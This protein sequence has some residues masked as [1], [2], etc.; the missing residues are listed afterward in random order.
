MIYLEM[1]K[2]S[3]DKK[4]GMGR[5]VRELS[6][7]GIYD[8]VL[9]AE[10]QKK[11]VPACI[12]TV[13][14]FP[15]VCYYS[16]ANEFIQHNLSDQDIIHFPMNIC[17]FE[18]IPSYVKVVITIHDLI[19]II[20]YSKNGDSGNRGSDGRMISSADFLANIEKGVERANLIISVSKNT[21]KDILRYTKCKRDKVRVIYEAVGEEFV[22]IDKKKRIDIR[23]EIVPKETPV[24]MAI[25]GARH[26]NINRLLWA[27]LLYRIIPGKT[28]GTLLLVGNISKKKKVFLD[29]FCRLGWV[30][31]PGRV[32]ERRL[33]E[34]YNITDLFFF[35]SLYEG[36]G[37]P[38]LE[39]M[40][41]GTRV[42][43]SNNSS[44]KELGWKYAFIVNPK[45]TF[46]I[47][48]AFF[49]VKENTEKDDELVNYAKSFSWE[50]TAKMHAYIFSSL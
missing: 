15:D 4:Y 12:K 30:I 27:Y 22:V 8:A 7:R 5:Y 38:L 49:Y 45:D 31:L 32:D 23:K 18:N 21:E 37:F 3:W 9:C 29:V 24:F 36:F 13:I 48:K 28:K 20:Q 41:C 10:S 14:S 26:K 11:N 40:R 47:V 50:K 19:P 33:V 6:V 34:C 1:G 46:S 42:V 44:L 25:N 16:K 35:I 43:C 39:A 17:I 2:Y